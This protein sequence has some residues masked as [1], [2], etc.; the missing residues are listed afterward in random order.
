MMIVKG[1]NYEAC[2]S[3]SECERYRYLLYRRWSGSNKNPTLFIML[4][5]S[6]ADHIRLDPTVSRCIA[7]AKRWGSPWLVVCNI[8]AIR[9]TDPRVMLADP[10]PIGEENDRMI[11][12]AAVNITNLGGKVICAWGAHSAHMGRGAAVRKMLDDAGVP[13]HYLRMGGQGHPWHP[14]YL[15][16]SLNPT[17]WV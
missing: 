10:E 17:E 3:F 15:P 16:G 1:N 9:A 5:P 8:F 12:A 4:N 13:L 14:L 7:F 11:M 2:A 6:K